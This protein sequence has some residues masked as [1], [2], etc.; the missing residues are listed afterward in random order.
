MELLEDSLEVALD[1][2]LARRLFCVLGQ[3]SGSGPRLSLL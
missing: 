3:R 2:F 1:D